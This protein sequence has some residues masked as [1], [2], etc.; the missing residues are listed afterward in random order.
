MLLVLLS[1]V[2][3]AVGPT[4]AR[5]AFDGGSNALT[6]VTMRGVIGA[7]LMAA[8]VAASGQGFRVGRR[9]LLPCLW[10]GLSCALMSYGFIGSVAYIP[11]SLAVPVFFAHPVLVAA[12][13][14]WRG[15]ERLTARKLALAFAAFAGIAL[16]LGGKFDD[17]DPI[18]IGLAVLA[19][20]TICSLI[21][22]SARAQETATSTQVNLYVTA[23]TVA[24][25]APA[26][27]ALDAW[28]F[29]SGIV[30]WL[31]LAAAG[32]GM[33]VGFLAFFAAFRHIGPVRATMVSN[34]EPLLG[35]LFAVATLGER[36]HPWQWGGVV[37]VV[38]ALVLFEA[39]AR[40]QPPS[41]A[42]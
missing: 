6:V 35:V 4:A 21:V 25:F 3:F 28:S 1:A 19:A 15:R 8:L 5:L 18:G 24:V 26:T 27:T 42:A 9:A 10:A 34:V 13:W 17:L 31:G 38:A 29:P 23:M 2:A 22:F 11:V 16:V 40:R 33:T 20:I 41:G 7:V 39:P 14:H 37:V 32:V 30:G 36:L 12:I